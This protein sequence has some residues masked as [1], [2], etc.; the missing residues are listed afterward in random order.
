MEQLSVPAGTDK[1]PPSQEEGGARGLTVLLRPLRAFRLIYLPLLMIYFAYGAS[2]IIDVTRDL[3]IKERLTLSP[4]EL[5]GIGVWLNLPWTVKMVF[6]ELV[7]S[8]PIFGSQRKAYILIGAA[9]MAC[10][11]LTLAG[12]AGGWIASAR[13]DHLYVLGS[14]LIVVGI[15]VQNVVAEAMSTEVVAR[16]D[17]AGNQRPEEDVRT[18]LGMVQ[19][20]G[21]LALSAGMLAVAGLSGWLASI[22]ARETVFLLGLMVPAISVTG[23]LLIS[24]ETTERRPLDWRILGGGIALGVV[25]LILALGSVP[26]SQELI[27]VLSMVVVCAMLVVVTRDIDADTRRSILYA[28]VVIFV[29]RASP[30]VGDG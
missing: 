29:F 24:F 19:V 13:I 30:T 9:V 28:S 8:V 22:L 20:L 5:A 2:G 25:I 1:P 4:A 21:R 23:V 16:R 3:W 17:E 10:G 14:M 7:D 27:F 26:F 11:M 18:D 6:G 15:V 12:T